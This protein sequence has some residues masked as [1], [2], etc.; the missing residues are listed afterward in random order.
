MR[1]PDYSQTACFHYVSLDL[2]RLVPQDHPLRAILPIANAALGRLTR[3]FTRMYSPIGR[4]SI[5]PERMLRALL[6]Q[7][8]YSIRSEDQLIQQLTYNMLFRWFVGLGIEEGPWDPSTFSANRDRFISAEVARKFMAEVVHIADE[9]G[10]LS[11]E[12]F[13]VDGT[14]IEAAASLK[15]F[16][17]KDAPPQPPPDDPG[18]PSIDFHGEKRIN[19][20]HASTTDPDARLYRKGKGKE[21]KLGFLGHVLMENR[22]GLIIK[23]LVTTADGTAECEAATSMIA[24]S[25][26]WMRRHPTLGADKAYDTN[27]FVSEMRAHGVTPHV[28]SK[29]KG[30]AIDERTKRHAGYVV[31][32]RMRKKV[33]EIFGWAKVIAG[34]RKARVRGEERVDLAFVFG[35]AV[36]NVLRI[37]NLTS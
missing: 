6:L 10:L 30:T 23:A 29:K 14:L 35:L 7:S 36:Y 11:R 33:E 18:N 32:Q 1:G 4:P 24:A 28:A 8:L 13:T 26:D 20:T 5:P 34:L 25:R 2:E 15:S 22:N 31:S 17:R 19:A 21:A 37:A 16:V 9:A 3:T 12:H 27:R